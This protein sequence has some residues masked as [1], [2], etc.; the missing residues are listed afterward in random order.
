MKKL[1]IIHSFLVLSLAACSASN[2]D[3][4]SKANTETT[5]SNIDPKAKGDN[6]CLLGYAEKYGEL[7]TKEMV[8][9]SSG[10]A[11]EV[12]TTTNTKT[13]P[14]NKYHLVQYSWK[15]GRIKNIGGM[16]IPVQD[17]VEL[18]GIEAISLSQFQ[19]SYKAVSKKEADAL[20]QKTSEAVAGKSDNEAINKR[21]KKLDEMGISKEDQKKMMDGF[22]NTAQEMTEGFSAIENIGD[23]ATWNSKTQ[24]LYVFQNGAKFTLV[25]DLIDAKKNKEVAITLAN[26]ILSKCN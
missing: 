14:N 1:F 16:N 12:M 7:L 11:A 15:T 23:A 17:Y 24:T 25:T 10:T 4:K 8:A 26:M 6:T 21:L 5:T 19:I 13:H 9:E 3:G 22:A 20:K 18:S 2:D